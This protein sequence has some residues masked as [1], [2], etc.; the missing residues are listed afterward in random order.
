MLP[1][2]TKGTARTGTIKCGAIDLLGVLLLVFLRQAIIYEKVVLYIRKFF[3]NC[4]K[5]LVAA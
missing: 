1:H 2:R 4:G 3:F 5:L